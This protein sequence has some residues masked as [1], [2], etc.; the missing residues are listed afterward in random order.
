LFSIQLE[1]II[2]LNSGN[3]FRL[4]LINIFLIKNFF[5]QGKLS[6]YNFKNIENRIIFSILQLSTFYK[7]SHLISQYISTQIKKSKNHYR[8]LKQ[9]LREVYKYFNDNVIKMKGLQV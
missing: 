5:V 6:R 3:F 1:S 2:F 7:T 4:D 8:I 9:F